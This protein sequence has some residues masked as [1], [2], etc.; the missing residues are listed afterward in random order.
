MKK[1]NEKHTGWSWL[2]FLL[3]PF[4]YI[5]HGLILKGLILIL[6]SIITFGFGIPI[7]WIYCG[8][9]GNSDNFENQ[10]KNYS[11]YSPSKI[12]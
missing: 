6:I 4:W 7:I 8:I 10:L 2:A 1:Q 12:K 11:K 3:G 5:A 9:R